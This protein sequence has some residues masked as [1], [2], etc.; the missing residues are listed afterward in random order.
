M[1]LDVQHMLP[2]TGSTAIE[3][4]MTILATPEGP[5]S[6]HV[7]LETYP[8]GEVLALVAQLDK[9]LEGAADIAGDALAVVFQT[10]ATLVDPFATSEVADGSD[11]SS[12]SR[13]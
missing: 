4:H 5:A 12:G 13:A 7:R 10:L 6:V 11:G 1:H 8:G 2:S 3:A 9:T